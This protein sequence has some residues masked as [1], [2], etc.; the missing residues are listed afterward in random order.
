MA[1]VGEQY[2][3]GSVVLGL[4]HFLFIK[5]KNQSTYLEVWTTTHLKLSLLL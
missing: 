2:V 4:A 5:K 3:A 1:C